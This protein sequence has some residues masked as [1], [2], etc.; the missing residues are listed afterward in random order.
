ME[1]IKINT[2]CYDRFVVT[3]D[4]KNRIT[5][6]VEGDFSIYLINPNGINVAESGGIDVTI[7]ELGNGKYQVNFQPNAL[8]IWSLMLVNNTYCPDGLSATY[9]CV[10]AL[11]GDVNDGVN[12]VN[13]RLGN[14]DSGS[15]ILSEINDNESKIDAIDSIV[16]AIK[17]KTDNLPTDPTSETNA[18]ANKTSIENKIDALS[19]PTASAIAQAVWEAT[20]EDYTRDTGTT[21]AAEI[22][23]ALILRNFS[24][25]NVTGVFKIFAKDGTTVL[26]QFTVNSTGRT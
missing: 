17:A 25:N 6:L 1:D 23:S 4:N 9:K 8:G 12:E 10:P 20:L 3:D 14:P 19:I 15:S 13:D 5:G 18:T 7:N 26:K 11:T 22:L 16:D 2:V 21:R 24:W